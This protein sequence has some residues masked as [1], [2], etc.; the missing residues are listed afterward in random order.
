[1]YK[2]IL[3]A[4]ARKKINK[5]PKEDGL[6][7]IRKLKSIRENPIPYLKKLKGN[8][9]W[10]LRVEDYRA[11]LDVIIVGKKIIVLRIDKR[12]KVYDR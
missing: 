12:S 2:V 9:F 8:R 1:M 7:I 6:K 10:R 11:V 4:K 5:L 3:S